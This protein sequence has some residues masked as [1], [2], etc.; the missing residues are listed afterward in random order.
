MNGIN[1]FNR[2]VRFKKKFT[3]D[4]SKPAL[5]AMAFLMGFAVAIFLTKWY[6]G[7]SV[8]IDKATFEL[9]IDYMNK[10]NNNFI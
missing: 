5:I 7:D 4:I 2:R 1:Q 3:P 9:F 6:I 10:M 8:M